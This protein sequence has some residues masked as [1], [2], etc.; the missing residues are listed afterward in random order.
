M[1]SSVNYPIR[2]YKSTPYDVSKH[3]DKIEGREYG[4]IYSVFN[5]LDMTQRTL[6]VLINET[7]KAEIIVVNDGSTDGTK[8]WLKTV[9]GPT[10]IN[11]DKNM[12]IAASQNKAIQLCLHRGYKYIVFHDNDVIM[13]KNW[14]EGLRKVVDSDKRIGIVSPIF[15]TNGAPQ[16]NKHMKPHFTPTV[17]I[18]KR[19]V[20]EDVG[21]FDENFIGFGSQ[22]VDFIMRVYL[23]GWRAYTVSWV[24]GRHFAHATV[25]VGFSRGWWSDDKMTKHNIAVWVAKWNGER[26]NRSRSFL[27]WTGERVLELYGEN[28]ING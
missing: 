8:D 19:E 5:R 11:C 4:V 16:I 20:F 27:K 1:S 9:V 6:P 28:W 13:G 25:G 15:N 10:V 3:P 24:A 22:C 12:G 26:F 2:E 21:L 14:I 17:N 18:V 7:K 23:A